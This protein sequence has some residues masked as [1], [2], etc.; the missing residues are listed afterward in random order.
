LT[1]HLDIEHAFEDDGGVSAPS[2]HTRLIANSEIP[3]HVPVKPQGSIPVIV[4]L[5]WSSSGLEEWRPARAIRWT[6][7]HV[8]VMWQPEPGNARTEDF[9]WLRAG[10]VL[11]S[12]SWLVPP[13]NSTAK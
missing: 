2:P 10:D 13:T 6:P 8:M 3:D 4:R 12:A 5:V 11:R 7:T 9:L 1:D